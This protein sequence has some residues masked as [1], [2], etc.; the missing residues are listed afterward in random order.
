METGRL[1]S[2]RCCSALFL[3]GCLAVHFRWVS[4]QE[5]M[6]LPRPIPQERPADHGQ[7]RT[8]S[9]GRP[10]PVVRIHLKCNVEPLQPHLHPHKRNVEPRSQVRWN[11]TSSQQMTTMVMYGRRGRHPA[12]F[13]TQSTPHPSQSL[14]GGVDACLPQSGTLVLPVAQAPSD[15]SLTD[16]IRR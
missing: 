5:A 9:N 14:N 3:Q 13:T 12:P 15:A 7:R 2:W 10:T 16:A 11:A 6:Q 8:H 1:Q 4:G